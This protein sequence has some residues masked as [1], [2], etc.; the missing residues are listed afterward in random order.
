M[1]LEKRQ[2]QCKIYIHGIMCVQGIRTDDK[3]MHIVVARKQ[4]EILRNTIWIAVKQGLHRQPINT[5][6]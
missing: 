6:N 2:N 4:S 5:N 1:K 3:H